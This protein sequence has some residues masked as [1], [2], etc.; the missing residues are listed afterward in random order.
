MVLNSIFV[1][2]V[3]VRVVNYSIKQ[4]RAIAVPY[5]YKRYA[6]M[7]SGKKIWNFRALK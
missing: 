3:G 7:N 2:S 1:M 6:K 4:R 5:L